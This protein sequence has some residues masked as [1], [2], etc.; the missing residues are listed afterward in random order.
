M[1]E[2]LFTEAVAGQCTEG[3]IPPSLAMNVKAGR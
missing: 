3:R 2:S 1:S